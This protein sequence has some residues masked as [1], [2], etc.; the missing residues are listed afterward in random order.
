MSIK[1]SITNGMATILGSALSLLGK[2]SSRYMI[3]RIYQQIPEDWE[4]DSVMSKMNVEIEALPFVSPDYSE[5]QMV[6]RIFIAFRKAKLDQIRS[7]TNFMPS[8]YW[9]QVLS[10]SYPNYTLTN[11][12]DFHVFLSN[13]GAW[14]SHLG[15]TWT[16]LV[17]QY[18]KTQRSR[19]YF[20]RKIIGRKIAWW[21]SF[22]SRG[23]GISALSQPRF[24]NLWGANVDGHFVT[25]EALL[26]EFY[27]RLISNSLGNGR[28]ILGEIGAGY[29]VLPYFILKDLSKFCYL[30]F[31]LPE[32][33]CCATYYL[34]KS[35]PDKKFL[36]YGEGQLNQQALGEY[37]FIFMPPY[38]IK[39]LPDNAVDIFI[40]LS[41]LGEMRPVSCRRYV[42][43]ICRTS[44]AFWHMNHEHTRV[45]FEDGTSLL[46]NEYPVPNDKFQLVSRN[47]EAL[48]AAWKG[49]FEPGYDIY[50]YYYRRK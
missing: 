44:R 9:Q 5:R 1:L 22:E 37:D 39:D 6:E 40:N 23:R 4:L 36:L 14:E 33:M 43:E 32:V 16:Y 17:R 26:N 11:L 20:E 21:L 25:Y 29:G 27:G 47:I 18:T 7:D 41:S 12:D 31:D 19:R 50:S 49:I 30:D 8:S 38:A 13:F 42:E 34:M 28:Q 48:N 46:N 24:G 10:S 3:K 45:N 15:I 35:F 2:K